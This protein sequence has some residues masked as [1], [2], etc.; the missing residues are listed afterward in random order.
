MRTFAL[1]LIEGRDIKYDAN[2]SYRWWT[3]ENRRWP[4]CAFRATYSAWSDLVA[5][6]FMHDKFTKRQ[7]ILFRW[8]ARHDNRGRHSFIIRLQR[9]FSQKFVRRIIII[10]IIII[11]CMWLVASCEKCLRNIPAD[12]WRTNFRAAVNHRNVVTIRAA[13]YL[14]IKSN[15]E[16]H[17]Y[18]NVNAFYQRWRQWKIDVWTH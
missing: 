11:E 4:L 10:I 18:A 12:G 5:A 2:M 3:E 15:S 8:R 14:A 6:N 7:V 13:K 9:G 16:L 1:R 17:T